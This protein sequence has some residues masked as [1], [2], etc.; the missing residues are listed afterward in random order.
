[1]LMVDTTDDALD[2]APSALTSNDPALVGAQLSLPEALW[3]ATNAPPKIIRF[4]ADA[5]SPS[6]PGVITIGAEGVTTTSVP[7]ASEMAQACI[8]GRDRGVII[9][10]PAGAS[11]ALLWS[12]SADS[13]Q[14]GLTL[15]RAPSELV[16][17]SRGQV[18][19]CRLQ[20]D[21]YG[22][23]DG[24]RPWTVEA[25]DDA[26]IGP[27]N[28]IANQH[29]GVRVFGLGARIWGNDI[30]YDPLTRR[31]VA[32]GM[33][34]DLRGGALIEDNVIAGPFGSN[35]ASDITV[36][37]NY[38]GVDRSGLALPAPR[39]G[40]GV[41]GGVTTFGP[42]NVIRNVDTA[43]SIADFWGAGAGMSVLLTR[44]IISGNGAGIVGSPVAS[45]NIGAASASAVNGTCPFDGTVEVF[46]DKGDQG[47]SYLG[48]VAC[49]ASLAW[50]LAASATV[51]GAIPSGRNVTATVTDSAGRTSGFS[52]PYPVP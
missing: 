50:T 11:N 44:N 35:M 25:G 14:I 40:F 1:V 27:G 17:Q 28:V 15:L 39:Y 51:T 47:E 13:L 37:G 48:S 26:R 18:A 19:A 2:A 5:F 34:F 6:A 3:I 9:Q 20:T 21:G 49:S 41:D 36:R 30:D 22:V 10:W 46:A 29:Y 4:L 24:D 8:D 43:V 45:P 7:W 16:V 38:F 52:A 31:A 23:F 32:T 12:I 33:A 42:G